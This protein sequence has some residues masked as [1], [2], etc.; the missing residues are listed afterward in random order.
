MRIFIHEG[1]VTKTFQIFS[2]SLQPTNLGT[3]P[4]IQKV[5]VT[6]PFVVQN[7][8]LTNFSLGGTRNIIPQIFVTHP[9]LGQH[10]GHI[11]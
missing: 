1:F 10:R 3:R 9:T 4:Q 7:L 11:K 8:Q 6:K 5:L 2:P